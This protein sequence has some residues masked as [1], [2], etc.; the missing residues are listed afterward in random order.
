MKPSMVGLFYWCNI[1][2]RV[3]KNWEK[4]I[5]EA[6]LIYIYIFPSNI[7]CGIAFASRSVSSE[8]PVVP[9]PFSCSSCITLMS[10]GNDCR[11]SNIIETRKRLALRLGPGCLRAQFHNNPRLAVHASLQDYRHETWSRSSGEEILGN[12]GRQMRC[13]GREKD[14]RRRK[15]KT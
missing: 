10:R 9:P 14:W 5:P 11:R 4:N 3:H 8:V 2:K 13:G 6:V 7:L 1:R 15:L 12:T